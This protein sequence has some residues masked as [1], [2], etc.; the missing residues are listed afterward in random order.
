MSN[1]QCEF[2]KKQCPKTIETIEGTFPVWTLIK[3]L[4]N[5]PSATQQREKARIDTRNSPSILDDYV[6]KQNTHRTVAE[7]YSGT[8]FALIPFHSCV[9]CARGITEVLE[10]LRYTKP[11]QK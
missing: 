7:M 6:F 8:S 5:Y 3:R 9:H 10:R 4:A 2:M 11:P 1:A